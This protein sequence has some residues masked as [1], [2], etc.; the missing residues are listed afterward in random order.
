MSKEDE[1]AKS[2]PQAENRRSRTVKL[3]A[4]SD[5]R[6]NVD[7]HLPNGN[8]RT[9]RMVVKAGEPVADLPDESYEQAEA[10]GQITDAKSFKEAQEKLDREAGRVVEP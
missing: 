3:V 4:A 1:K 10:A 6:Y 8:V 9:D 2:E 7:V 5:I